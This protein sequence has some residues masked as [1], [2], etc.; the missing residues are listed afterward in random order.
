MLFCYSLF[1]IGLITFGLGDD[2]SKQQIQ[3]VVISEQLQS[4]DK[5]FKWLDVDANGNIT[6]DEYLKR[7]LN[8][9]EA[10]KKEFKQIDLNSKKTFFDVG[11]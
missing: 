11:D 2:L 6:F 8:Y 4:P 9:V 5:T 7:D 1:F 10:I 3:G